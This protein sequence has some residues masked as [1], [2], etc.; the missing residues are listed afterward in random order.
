MNINEAIELFLL[1][2]KAVNNPRTVKWKKMS[3]NRFKDFC[4]TIKNIEKL[5]DLSINLIY[6]YIAY[7]KSFTEAVTTNK[8]INLL[9]DFFRMFDYDIGMHKVKSLTVKRK[10]VDRLS[11]EELSILFNYL[12]NLEISTDNNNLVYKSLFYFLIDSGCR[13]NETLSIKKENI[14]FNNNVIKLVDNIKFEK[15]R[16]VFFSDFSKP[17]LKKLFILSD[18]EYLF[19]NLRL[20]RKLDYD[21]DVQY[22]LRKTRKELK[23]NGIRPHRLRHTFAT[24]SLQNGMS[25]MSLQ[26]ILGHESLKSTQIYLHSDYR[27]AKNDYD[28]FSPF[29]KQKHY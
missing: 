8:K 21:S 25:L 4:N 19:N 11:D 15:E 29:K 3:L 23:I 5:E 26:R 1:S 22:F 6:E 17:Y 9:R 12:D 24:I 14:N 28:N 7:E 16:F 10:L 2:A 27:T 18:N 13:I 20:K